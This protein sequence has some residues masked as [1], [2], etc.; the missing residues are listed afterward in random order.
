ME[1]IS[2]AQLLVVQK[3]KVQLEKKQYGI[4]GSDNFQFLQKYFNLPGFK[5][6]AK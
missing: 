4:G 5:M 3:I 6:P 2:R 1:C